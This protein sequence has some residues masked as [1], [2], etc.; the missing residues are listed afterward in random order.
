[1][2]QAKTLDELA[3]QV[4]VRMESGYDLFGSLHASDNWYFREM[5]KTRRATDGPAAARSAASWR[6]GQ[7]VGR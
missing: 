6:P 7:G 4:R 5:V 2:V 1:M 3:Q